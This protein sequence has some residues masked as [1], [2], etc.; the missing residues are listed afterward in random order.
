[1]AFL[2]LQ[3]DGWGKQV[4]V[5]V[6]GKAQDETRAVKQ[7]FPSGEFRIIIHGIDKS[8]FAEG[9]FPLGSRSA[10]CGVVSFSLLCLTRF[11][12]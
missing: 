9:G 1:M 2:W 7:A 8:Y 4:V 11:V 6:R 3:N 12:M 5:S 10:T